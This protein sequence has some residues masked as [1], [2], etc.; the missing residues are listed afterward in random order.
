LLSIVS[1]G[2]CLVADRHPRLDGVDFQFDQGRGAVHV[3]GM[4][5]YLAIFILAFAAPGGASCGGCC[6]R[7]NLMAAGPG[8][9]ILRR[10][11]EGRCAA[12]W[13]FSP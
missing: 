10:M 3:G 4:N 13:V 2:A 9:L 11:S 12:Q 5:V 6:R 1:F 8:T 7:A